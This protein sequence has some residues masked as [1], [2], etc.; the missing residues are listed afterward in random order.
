MTGVQTCA[1][2]I[3]RIETLVPIEPKVLRARLSEILNVMLQDNRSKW[4]LRSDGS[5]VQAKPNSKD[6]LG[7]HEQ[8]MKLSILHC[9]PAILQNLGSSTLVPSGGQN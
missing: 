4:S 5:Y 7:A 2:P 8:L 1:L 3:S 9:Q 6:E